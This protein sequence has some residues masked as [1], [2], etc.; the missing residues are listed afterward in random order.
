[1]VVISPVQPYDFALSMRAIRAFRPVPAAPEKSLRLAAR[2]GGTPALIEVSEAPGQTGKLQAI[3]SPA[4]DG[5]LL[6]SIVAWVLFAELDLALFHR[7]I[8]AHPGLSPIAKRLYGLKPMRPVSL[9]E[10]FVTAITEEQI[11]LPPLTPSATGLS[12]STARRSRVNGYSPNRPPLRKRAWKTCAP[13]VFRGKKPNIYGTLPPGS[14]EGSLTSKNL[15][16]WATMKH[17]RQS[18]DCEV[19]APG[20]RIISSYAAWPGPIAFPPPTSAFKASWVNTWEKAGGSGPM[21]S[22]RRW[23]LSGLTGVCWLFTCWWNTG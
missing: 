8:S 4:S 6:R 10:M 1:M 22:K 3:S 9:F 5:A 16:R 2:I 19:L 13:V 11:S 7:L 17:G 12:K 23:N 20:R 14:P 21:S 15:S 18:W